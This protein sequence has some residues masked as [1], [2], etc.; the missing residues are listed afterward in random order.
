MLLR[1]YRSG[2]VSVLPYTVYT[3]Y[4]LRDP[5]PVTV[6][7]FPILMLLSE[8]AGALTLGVL[9]CH[10][11]TPTGSGPQKGWRVLHTRSFKRW[12][13]SGMRQRCDW[14]VRLR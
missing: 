14:V 10:L 13:C 1:T 5:D 2:A 7:D 9:P 4:F 11:N 8:A 12:R 6:Y 3:Y